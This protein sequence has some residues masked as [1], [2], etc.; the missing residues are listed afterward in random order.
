VAGE[1]KDVTGVDPATIARFYNFDWT[2]GS[3]A[4]VGQLGSDG[5]LVTQ[6][7]ADDEDLAVGDPLSIQTA[8]GDKADVVVR[9]IYD[10]PEI[11]RML[12]PITIGQQAF[13]RVFPQPKNRFTFIDAGPDANPALTAA[14]ADFRDHHPTTTLRSDG[15][16]SGGRGL[17]RGGD[18]GAGVELEAV[19]G[20]ERDLGDEWLGAGEPEPHAVADGGHG[21]HLG[22]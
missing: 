6:T 21:E 8:S 11:E 14:A 9:G 18:L 2:D 19:G 5:A 1:E 15:H 16:E 12:G 20:G 22:G 4:A 13:D 7:Y 3:D 17:P 10:P